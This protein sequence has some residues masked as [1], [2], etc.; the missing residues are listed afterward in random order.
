[1]RARTGVHCQISW[2]R[3][4]GIDCRSWRGNHDLPTRIAQRLLHTVRQPQA[5]TSILTSSSF[6]AS[7]VARLASSHW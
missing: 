1:M 6:G 3:G 2:M 4:I 5:P 7:N